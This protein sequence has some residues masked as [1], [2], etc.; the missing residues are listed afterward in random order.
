MKTAAK[1]PETVLQWIKRHHGTH[2]QHRNLFIFHIS[3]GNPLVVNWPNHGPRVDVEQGAA[4]SR[5]ALTVADA[6]S[7]AAVH[8]PENGAVVS[9]GWD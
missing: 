5:E 1:L 3:E 7:L 2:L 9:S 6:R 4:R 8:V